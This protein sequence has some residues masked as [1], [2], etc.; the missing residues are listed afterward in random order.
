MKSVGMIRMELQY[1]RVGAVA[2][3]VMALSTVVLVLATPGPAW[4]RC[5]Y[6]LATP[7]PAWLR[8]ASVLAI[9]ALCGEA[10]QRVAWLKAPRAARSI[11]LQRDG[12]I[13]VE[14]P[15]GAVRAGRLRARSFVAPWLVIVR[16][17]PDGARRDAT[18]L[19]LPDMA[20][21]EERRRL[22]VLLRWSPGEP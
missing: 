1:S 15:S 16:W 21:A 22:R 11:S 18:I 9:A 12:R 7:W 17:R 14:S 19:V 5:A 13:E 8:C 20:P 2:L 4:V 10:L 6:V 3:G